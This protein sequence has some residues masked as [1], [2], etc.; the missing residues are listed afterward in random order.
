MSSAGPRLSGDGRLPSWAE[1]F[2][3]YLTDKEM[4]HALA[5]RF[6]AAQSPEPTGSPWRRRATGQP[7]LWPHHPTQLQGERWGQS[8]HPCFPSLLKCQACTVGEITSGQASDGNTERLSG[9]GGQGG[10]PSEVRPEGSRKLTGD[11]VPSRRSSWSQGQARGSEGSQERPAEQKTLCLGQR[12]KVGGPHTKEP[13]TGGSPQ[14]PAQ[15]LLSPDLAL[16]PQGHLC[17]A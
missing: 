3:A 8:G 5:R 15:T 6:R 16:G 10:L 17:P 1:A 2:G 11:R 13:C 4:G 9:S 7:C 14:P 12:C